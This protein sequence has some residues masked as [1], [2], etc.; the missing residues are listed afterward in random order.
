MGLFGRKT[1]DSLPRAETA[2]GDG[3]VGVPLAEAAEYVEKMHFEI[4]DLYPG[5]PLTDAVS[6]KQ[7]AL[8]HV[9]VADVDEPQKLPAELY[10]VGLSVIRMG[11][12]TREYEVATFGPLEHGHP[13][14]I[15]LLDMRLAQEAEIDDPVAE[16]CFGWAQVEPQNAAHDE[17]SM[18]WT[19]PGMGG[20]LRNQL[21]VGA[22]ASLVPEDGPPAPLDYPALRTLWVFGFLTRCAEE[23]LAE[24]AS[25]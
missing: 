13:G 5:T 24:R 7:Q 1:T 16:I 21:A 23:V 14:F 9:L 15:E 2:L 6:L 8:V 18:L 20:H 12:L 17:P 25:G 4:V 3:L 19:I 10:A 11:Y 22:I